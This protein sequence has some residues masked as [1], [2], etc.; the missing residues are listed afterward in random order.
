MNSLSVTSTHVPTAASMSAQVSARPNRVAGDVA[1]QIAGK[2]KDALEVKR[3]AQPDM[4]TNLKLI[5]AQLAARAEQAANVNRLDISYNKQEAVLSVKVQHQQTGDL[6]RELK[7]KD[8]KAIAYS[9]HGY[10]GAV[11]DITA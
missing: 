8:Y 3:Q 7:F 5:E 10:K 6:I 11:V 4:L 9:P 1:P 2:S